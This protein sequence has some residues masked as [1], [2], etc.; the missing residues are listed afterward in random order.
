[1]TV[2][3]RDSHR[4]KT[5]AKPTQ[6]H[7]S[8]CKRVQSPHQNPSEQASNASTLATCSIFVKSTLA[9]Y[10]LYLDSSLSSHLIGIHMYPSA[11]RPS[12][13]TFYD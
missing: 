1:M 8:R 11:L 12:C 4:P 9:L 13:L 7:A 2:T 6:E 10:L 5:H 3:T